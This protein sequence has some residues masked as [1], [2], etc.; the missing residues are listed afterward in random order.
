MLFRLQ[1]HTFLDDIFTAH[2]GCVGTGHGGHGGHTSHDSHPLVVL[3]RA[4]CIEVMLLLFLLL[5]M[6]VNVMQLLLLL[7]ITLAGEYDGF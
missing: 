4:H 5:A 1:F 3:S 6:L 2:V 7:Q